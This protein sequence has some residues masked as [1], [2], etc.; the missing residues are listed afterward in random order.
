MAAAKP[1]APAL[2]AVAAARVVQGQASRRKAAC[3]CA[4]GA[5]EVVAA[6]QTKA[7][8]RAGWG[9]AGLGRDAQVEGM[10]VGH[11][12]AD[13]SPCACRGLAAHHESEAVVAAG[14]RR[15]VEAAGGLLG[16]M[17]AAVVFHRHVP[18][19]PQGISR[20]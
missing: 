6:A 8:G 14:G 17:P 16:C 10:M 4:R 2:A 1:C 18:V 20:Q 9:T 11:H 19:P 3:C 12:V 7:A 15:G 5:A 13:H